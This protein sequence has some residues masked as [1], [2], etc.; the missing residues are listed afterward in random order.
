MNKEEAHM[1]EWG[2]K[3]AMKTNISYN[4]VFLDEKQFLIMKHILKNIICLICTQKT[5]D[6]VLMIRK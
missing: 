4:S 2:K 3:L 5:L 6:R 1:I